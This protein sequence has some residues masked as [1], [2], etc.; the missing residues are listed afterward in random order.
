MTAADNARLIKEAKYRVLE[1][2]KAHLWA[3]YEE[4]TISAAAIKRLTAQVEE[5]NAAQAAS[6]WAAAA[7]VLGYSAGDAINGSDANGRY[8]RLARQLHPDRRR[9]GEA[10]TAAFQVLTR[11]ALVFRCRQIKSLKCLKAGR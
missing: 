9:S 6:T 5:G 10:T 4:G 11:L 3:Q 1:R 2:L 8:R 7:Y